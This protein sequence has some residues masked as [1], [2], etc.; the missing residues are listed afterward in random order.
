MNLEKFSYKKVN[1]TN[2]LAIQ[3]IKKGFIQGLV[4]AE[5]QK[6]G[7]G[8][9]G[10]KW[11]SLK[12]NLFLSIFFKIKKNTTIKKITSINCKIIKRILSKLYKKKLSIKLP[13]DLLINKKKVCGILQ[14]TIINNNNKFIIIGVGINLSKNPI[15]INY[16]T[17]NLLKET[18]IKISR[19]KLLKI[20]KDNFEKKL[21]KF[22]LKD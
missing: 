7:R 14:E 6:K 4:F 10:K 18:S 8:Q 1:S 19:I 9:Y 12:G 11:V 5:E 16:P 21:K 17:T 13:N 20:I 2:D 3:K 15:I 22:A